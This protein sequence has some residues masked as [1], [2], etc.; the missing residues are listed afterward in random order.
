MDEVYPPLGS[1]YAIRNIMTDTEKTVIKRE[2]I[3]IPNS[4][5]IFI[6]F[7]ERKSGFVLVTGS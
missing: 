6:L 3:I 7:V 2:K 1:K 4:Q 5:I